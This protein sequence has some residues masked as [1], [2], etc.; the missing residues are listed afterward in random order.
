[1][2]TRREVHAK[3]DANNI[4]ISELKAQVG[5]SWQ[6]NV[7]VK[8]KVA[9]SVLQYYKKNTREFVK[10]VTGEVIAAVQGG[11]LCDNGD[12]D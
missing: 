3:R 10:V 4:L 8:D 1:M 9:K 5:I 7:G 12:Y 2:E 6:K 11:A